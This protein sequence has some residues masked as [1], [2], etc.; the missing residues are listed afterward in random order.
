[1]PC[2]CRASHKIPGL[3]RE[4]AR[5]ACAAKAGRGLLVQADYTYCRRHKR[6]LNMN[7]AYIDP[8]IQSATHAFRTML[9]CEVNPGTPVAKA[10]DTY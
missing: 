2:P 4:I 9:S 3:R 8:F 7:P 1:M 10:D 6:Q 5:A